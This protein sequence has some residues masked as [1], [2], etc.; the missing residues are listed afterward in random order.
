MSGNEDYVKR[1]YKEAKG[2][3]QMGDEQQNNRP[4]FFSEIITPRKK[5][6]DGGEA[7]LNQEI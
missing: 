1:D 7:A 6:S 5:Q 2:Q 4:S 3:I